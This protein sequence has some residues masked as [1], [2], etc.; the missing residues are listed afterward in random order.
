ATAPC[1]STIT[2]ARIWDEIWI[3][4]ARECAAS[5][6]REPYSAREDP[7]TIIVRE[8]L[9]GPRHASRSDDR[10]FRAAVVRAADLP[11]A[12]PARVHRSRGRVEL[13]RQ[14]AQA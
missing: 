2:A 12:R 5:I 8:V 14:G 9:R 13:P 7:E 4:S 11:R 6:G 10:L 1:S 3:R